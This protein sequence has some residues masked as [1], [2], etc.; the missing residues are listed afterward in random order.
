[1]SD[2]H[3]PS[4]IS[5]SSAPASIDENTNRHLP[6][7]RRRRA[8]LACQR[9][10][11][12]RVRCDFAWVDSGCTNCR[13]DGL[14]CILR[15]SKRAGR[16]VQKGTVCIPR[17][18]NTNE[19]NRDHARSVH[20]A[21]IGTKDCVSRPTVRPECDSEASSHSP[22]SDTSS[23][24]TPEGSVGAE[25]FMRDPFLQQLEETER[26]LMNKLFTARVRTQTYLTEMEMQRVIPR[27]ISWAIE[28]FQ[29]AEGIPP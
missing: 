7:K 18:I 28:L 29:Q 12:R 20:S 9:C 22:C 4:D 21:E 13:L 1:M 26:S 27:D 19:L 3:S 14:Q 2:C 16:Y 5:P 10:H 15:K 11:N 6:L 23:S 8:P 24:E 25:R 17:R